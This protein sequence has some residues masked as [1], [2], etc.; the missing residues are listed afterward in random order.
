MQVR[1]A[2]VRQTPE[3]VHYCQG[4][5]TLIGYFHNRMRDLVTA[6]EYKTDLATAAICLGLSLLMLKCT[7]EQ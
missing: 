5:V 1:D 2:R 6:L 3:R 4:A 7:C